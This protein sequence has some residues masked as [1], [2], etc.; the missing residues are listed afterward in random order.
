MTIANQPFDA[1]AYCR[2]AAA[3]RNRL[4]KPRNAINGQKAISAPR[5]VERS[6]VRPVLAERNPFQ[7]HVKAYRASSAFAKT[8]KTYLIRRSLELGFTLKEVVG[9]FIFLPFVMARRMLAWELREKFGLT[10]LQISRLL[11][12]DHSSIYQLFTHPRPTEEEASMRLALEPGVTFLR[13]F[14]NAYRSE[15]LY[16]EISAIYRITSRSIPILAD[17]LGLQRRDLGSVKMRAKWKE[18]R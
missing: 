9:P 13:S 15:V 2:N 3:I 12:R 1:D 18:V 4:M 17:R 6:P 16:S 14:Q 5:P 8:P 10:E 11:K 7:F